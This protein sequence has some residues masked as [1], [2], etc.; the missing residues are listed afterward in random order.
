MQRRGFARVYDLAQR[1]V[2]EQL[3]RAELSKLE[4]FTQMVA[5]SGRHIGVGTIGDLADYYRIKRADVTSVIPASGLVEV[6]VQGW[7]EKAFADAAALESLSTGRQATT[8]LS[9]F[10]SLIWDRARAERVFGFVH[11]LEAYVPKDKRIHGYYSM[12]LLAGGKIVG[13]VDP[14][15]RDG[16]FVAKNVTM[17]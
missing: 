13:K 17:D 7:K 11:R 14:A 10:D 15:R 8:L 5:K 16:S 6:K 4:C 3:L 2:P 12:P 1:R 9:P